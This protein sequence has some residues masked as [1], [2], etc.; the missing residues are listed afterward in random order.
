[1][2]RRI[3]VCLFVLGAWPALASD[4]PGIRN[5]D[6]VDANV[7]R[8][9]QPAAEGFQYLAGIG[10]KMVIDLREAGTRANREKQI[11]MKAGMAYRNVPMTGRT[12]PTE[13][14]L[15]TILP[16]LE[17]APDGPVFVHCNRGADR[18]GSVIAAYHIEHDHW[19]NTRAL[20]DAKAHGMGSRQIPRQNFIKNFKPLP[21]AAKNPA[22]GGSPARE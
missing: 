20:K 1:M 3:G 5:F 22:E 8:G 9:A 21:I 4:V 12:P 17:S 14:E 19:E 7:Y 2:L 15:R 18:T 16:L 10:V 11:V 13:A 6:K